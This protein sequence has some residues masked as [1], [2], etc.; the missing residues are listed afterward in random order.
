MDMQT[1][2][3]FS[4]YFGRLFCVWC[5]IKSIIINPRVKGIN[6]RRNNVNFRL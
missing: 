6:T 5:S 4:L 1:K 2:K 3:N